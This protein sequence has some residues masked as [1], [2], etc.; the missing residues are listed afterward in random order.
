MKTGPI[1]QWTPGRRF[2]KQN[3]LY[4]RIRGKVG[5][6]FLRQAALEMG[7]LHMVRLFMKEGDY[8]ASSGS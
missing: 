3:V 5:M 1:L 6:N 8:A 2:Y 4:R 7:I